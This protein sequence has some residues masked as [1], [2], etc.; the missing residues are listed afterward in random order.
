MLADKDLGN[1][2]KENFRQHFPFLAVYQQFFWNGFFSF[3]SRIQADII[4]FS[5]FDS[6]KLLSS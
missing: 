1:V 4:R 6:S 3:L 2:S 5:Y